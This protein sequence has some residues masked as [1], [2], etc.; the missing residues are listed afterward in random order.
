MQSG[1]AGCRRGEIAVKQEGQMKC[2]LVKREEDNSSVHMKEKW[3]SA[4]GEG[5]VAYE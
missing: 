3:R 5:R 1:S 2:R 4:L